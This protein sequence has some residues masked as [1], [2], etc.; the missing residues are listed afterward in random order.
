MK[1][2]DLN[3]PKKQKRDSEKT[4]LWAGGRLDDLEREKFYGTLTLIYENG[5]IVRSETK[6]TEIPS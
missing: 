2:V 5:C 3:S 6:K 1:E 4:K